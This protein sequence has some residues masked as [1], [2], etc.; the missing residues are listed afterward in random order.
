MGEFQVKFDGSQLAS[1]QYVYELR[2]GDVTM[3]KKMML[4]K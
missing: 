4:I 2:S 1:G 3:T